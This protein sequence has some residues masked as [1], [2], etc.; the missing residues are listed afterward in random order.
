MNTQ[1]KSC[2]A[3]QSKSKHEVH[4]DSSST[5]RAENEKYATFKQLWMCSLPLCWTEQSGT[6]YHIS[7]AL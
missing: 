4:I 7:H 2:P 6:F 1:E 5:S 3:L